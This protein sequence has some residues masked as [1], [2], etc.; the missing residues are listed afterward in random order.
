MPSYGLACSECGQQMVKAARSLPQGQARC[1]RCRRLRPPAPKGSHKRPSLPC[2]SCGKLLW[3]S[4]TSSPEGQARCQPCRRVAAGRRPDQRVRDVAT[5]PPEPRACVHCRTT[6]SPRRS[7]QRYCAPECHNE[8]RR[9]RGFG[10]RRPGDRGYGA[11]HQKARRAAAAT[12]RESDP[13]ARCGEQLGPMGPNLHYDH[14]DDR[15][16][17]LGFS[18]AACNSREGARR[19][20]RVARIGGGR[21]DGSL[22]IITRTR[23]AAVSALEACP[24]GRGAA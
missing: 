21:C 19:G 8:V 20:G 16:G 13:C 17:Y 12:H 14:T 11:A 24:V 23:D 4:R 18:H 10:P 1:Q 3:Q 22:N 2:A 15:T 9:L 6:F 5:L 7:N